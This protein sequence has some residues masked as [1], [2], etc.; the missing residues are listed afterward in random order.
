MPAVDLY[1]ANCHCFFRGWWFRFECPDI[2]IEWKNDRTWFKMP[3]KSYWQR[4]NEQKH[5]WAVQSKQIEF[6][7][8]FVDLSQKQTVKFGGGRFIWYFHFFFFT[9]CLAFSLFLLN[10]HI[11]KFI[12]HGQIIY[13]F[14]LIIHKLCWYIT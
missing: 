4:R 5:L 14:R 6:K 13:L 11:G 2:A 12:L 8:N 3:P 10:G 9:F 1:C 7:W